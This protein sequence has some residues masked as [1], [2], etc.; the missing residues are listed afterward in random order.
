MFMLPSSKVNK[1]CDRQG[2]VNSYNESSCVLY[3]KF[4]R[5][6]RKVTRFEFLN[7]G[8]RLEA[9]LCAQNAFFLSLVEENWADSGGAPCLREAQVAR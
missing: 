4:K 8:V 7:A 1:Y 3:I 9:K 5:L 6:R 2:R